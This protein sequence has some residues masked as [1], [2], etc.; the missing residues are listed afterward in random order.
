MSCAHP[1]EGECFVLFV[2]E[3]SEQALPHGESKRS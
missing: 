2:A 3:T 1:V